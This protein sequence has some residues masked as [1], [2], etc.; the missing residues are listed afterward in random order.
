[1]KKVSVVV[2]LLI[3][4]M[5]ISYLFSCKPNSVEPE[6]VRADTTLVEDVQPTRVDSLSNPPPPV[7]PPR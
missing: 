1:M 4:A 7:R 2:A 3:L 5:S 6:A